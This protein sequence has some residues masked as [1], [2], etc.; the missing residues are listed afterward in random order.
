MINLKNLT[1]SFNAVRFT[2]IDG[3]DLNE[4]ILPYLSS[5]QTFVFDICTILPSCRTKSSLSTK[6]LENTFIHWKYSQ[7]NCSVDHFSNG[8]AY[9]HIYSIPYKMTHFMYLTNTIRNQNQY[10]QF[11]ITLILYDTRPFEH[12][13]FEWMSKAV[14]RLKYLTIEIS[15]PQL[16]QNEYGSMGKKTCISYN[17]LTRLRVFQANIDYVYQFLCHT[18]AYV[19]QLNVLEIQYEKLIT[20]TNN[21]SS[22]ATRINCSQLKELRC[23]EAIVYPQHFHHYFPSLL[24]NSNA[25]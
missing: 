16:K 18:K 17:H 7:V 1:L 4:K 15:T 2:V 3:V 25:K 24:I 20:V 12:D 14:P 13:F 11:V 9:C 23:Q 10:F 8:L 22:P 5:L 19:P 21:F 6:D